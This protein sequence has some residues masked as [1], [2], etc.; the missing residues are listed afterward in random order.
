M[1]TQALLDIAD[2]LLEQI[3]DDCTGNEDHTYLILRVLLVFC[4]IYII[5]EAFS[6]IPPTSLSA[7][8]FPLISF[9][10]RSLEILAEPWRQYPQDSRLRSWNVSKVQSHHCWFRRLPSRPC[11][12]WNLK[13]RLS[14]QRMSKCKKLIQINKDLEWDSKSPHSAYFILLLSNCH[15]QQ[16]YWP[17]CGQERNIGPCCYSSTQN[18]RL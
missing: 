10:C 13:M 4:I 12:K 5:S 11:G 15:F 14:P 17:D 9:Q 1:V 18:M 8:W 2:Y 7:P 6:W 16:A 3:R